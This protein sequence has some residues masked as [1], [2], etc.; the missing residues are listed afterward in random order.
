[1]YTIKVKAKLHRNTKGL[2]CSLKKIQSSLP[3]YGQS[4]NAGGVQ[5]KLGEG[6]KHGALSN[7][8]AVSLELRASRWI[9]GI[10]HKIMT[11]FDENLCK[12][13]KKEKQGRRSFA[14]T[15]CPL[16]EP[17]CYSYSTAL[18]RGTKLELLKP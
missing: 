13:G 7:E 16:C 1:M 14:F 12:K 15:L 2:A 10:K 8:K 4:Q 11:A 17:L 5:Y 18:H 6:R 9:G 3:W